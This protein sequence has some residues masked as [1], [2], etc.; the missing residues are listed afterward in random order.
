MSEAAEVT[1]TA[2]PKAEVIVIKMADGREVG[3]AGKRKMVKDY[4]I[5]ANSNTV[6]ARIDFANGQTVTLAIDPTIQTTGEDSV[7]LLLQAAGHGL[8]QKLGDEAA[9]EKDVDDAYL[10]I[11]DLA[12][13]LAKGEWGVQRE[14]GGFSGAS[15]VLQAIL[16]AKRES[17]PDYTIEQVKEGLQKILDAD[18]AK[19]EGENRKPMTRQ[20]LYQSFRN[21]T[22]K[23]GK[24]VKR[25]EEEKAAK[26]QSAV[27]ADAAVEAL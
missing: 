14:A 13:R 5:D 26:S 11:S 20:A 19:A 4:I 9:S 1:K 17:A 3:F 22:T 6:T 24:I 27:D 2:K 15:V 23:V 25:L 16:E 12:D 18:K 8:V 7:P 21:P 10:A